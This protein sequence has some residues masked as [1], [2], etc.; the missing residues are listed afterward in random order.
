MTL[1]R[2]LNTDFEVVF[3][4]KHLHCHPVGTG[5]FAP[6]RPPLMAQRSIG[7]ARPGAFSVNIGGPPHSQGFLGAPLLCPSEE[8]GMEE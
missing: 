7:T 3:G 1:N 5:E 2:R 6:C 4:I 8:M